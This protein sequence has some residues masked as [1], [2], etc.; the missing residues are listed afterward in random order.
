M[1][2]FGLSVLLRKDSAGLHIA[3][4][5]EISRVVIHLGKSVEKECRRGAYSY[6]GVSVH[7]DIDI[8]PAGLDCRWVLKEADTAL[9]IGIS[10]NLLR[11]AAEAV[12]AGSSDV[13]LLNRFAVRDSQIKKLA[14]ALKIESDEGF[15][16]G[17]LY[18]ESVS[19]AIALRLM[20][21]HS[22]LVSQPD[23]ETIR[24]ISGR[25]LRRVLAFIED[26]LGETLS[27]SQIAA[28]SGLS[29]SHCQRVFGN[30]MGTSLHRYV[31]QQRVARAQSL[32]LHT[33]LPIEHI[34][35]EVG[36]SHQSHLAS[37]MRRILGTSPARLRRK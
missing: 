31:T 8:V 35:L 2:D 36:F 33:D 18:W 30:A 23:G 9:V 20:R 27:V 13:T 19:T 17:S 7:G 29:V 28:E 3:P 25:T 1:N 15:G 26:H 37:H 22:S 10:S 4:A 21:R 34:A 32:L 24:S 16:N 5:Q 14:W 12:G 6:R 11:T